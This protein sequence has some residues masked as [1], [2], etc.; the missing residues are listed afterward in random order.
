M[1]PR[2]HNRADA[3]ATTLVDNQLHDAFLTLRSESGSSSANVVKCR[4]FI[5]QCAR[6]HGIQ[7]VMERT[8]GKELEY[9]VGSLVFGEALANLKQAKEVKE[10]FNK[11]LLL[12]CRYGYIELVRYLLTLPDF[13][14]SF[15]NNEAL[16]TAQKHRKFEIYSLLVKDNRVNPPNKDNNYLV[17][18]CVDGNLAEVCSVFVDDLPF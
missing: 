16:Y 9:K 12:A 3:R 14:P 6:D 2:H 1:Y 18:A 11:L 13:D 7:Y 4:E 5:T 17:A 15:D 8:N 10:N